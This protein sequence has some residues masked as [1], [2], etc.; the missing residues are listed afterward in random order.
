MPSDDGLRLEDIHRVQHLGS[1]AIEPRIHI[2]PVLIDRF[3]RMMQEHFAT[4]KPLSFDL[5]DVTICLNATAQNL[6]ACELPHIPRAN[7]RLGYASAGRSLTQ[8]THTGCLQI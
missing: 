3:G 1:Q 6:L 4:L 8:C 5:R 2:D 7:P